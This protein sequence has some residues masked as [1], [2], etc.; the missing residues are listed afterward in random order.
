MDRPIKVCTDCGMML[1]NG[2]FT[3]DYSEWATAD[4]L[5]AAIERN[6]PSSDY[7][8]ALGDHENDDEFSKSQC[9]GCGSLL[10]GY[11]YEFVALVK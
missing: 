2:E 3:P 10:H 7:I 4:E 5:M 9:D 1:A 11:R 6:W 8:L